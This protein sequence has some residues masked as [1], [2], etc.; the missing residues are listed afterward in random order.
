MMFVLISLI[1]SWSATLT[2]TQATYN[3][4]GGFSMR[5]SG[6]MTD[7]SRY[8]LF[9]M[10]KSIPNGNVFQFDNLKTANPLFITTQL[11]TLSKA[12]VVYKFSSKYIINGKSVNFIPQNP[13][14]PSSTGCGIYTISFDCSSN[15]PPQ[16]CYNFY[17]QV[18]PISNTGSTTTTQFD[19]TNLNNYGSCSAL[20][21]T[22]NNTSYRGNNA[23]YTSE[24]SSC[25]GSSSRATI[26][27]QTQIIIADVSLSP[28]FVVQKSALSFQFLQISPATQN[29]WLIAATKD[30]LWNYPSINPT[31]VF[32]SSFN[33]MPNTRKVYNTIYKTHLVEH[34]YKS[35]IYCRFTLTYTGFVR[36]IY[37]NGYPTGYYAPTGPGLDTVSTMESSTRVPLSSSILN[38]VTIIGLRTNQTQMQFIDCR[39]SWTGT[40][41]LN[42]IQF[43]Y[44]VHNVSFF[45]PQY[46]IS[47]LTTGQCSSNCLKCTAENCIVCQ[48]QYFLYQ[49]KCYG[50]CPNTAPFQNPINICTDTAGNIGALLETPA[51]NKGSVT[52][53]G[54]LDVDD[55]ITYA[56][57]IHASNSMAF[58]NTAFAAMNGTLSLAE[59]YP[60]LLTRSGGYYQVTINLMSIGNTTDLNSRLANVLYHKLDS[61]SL[62]ALPGFSWTTPLSSVS[63]NTL[64]S[65]LTQIPQ[66]SS[67]YSINKK[68]YYI[69][70]TFLA[71][72]SNCTINVTS[73]GEVGLTRNDRTFLFGVNFVTK[74]SYSYSE[75]PAGFYNLQFQ[76]SN[77]SYLDIDII[78]SSLTSYAAT[79]PYFSHEL[80]PLSV[81]TKCSVP[82][83]NNCQGTICLSC[84]TGYY[85]TSDQSN[86]V[87]DCTIY[88]QLN[89]ILERKCVSSCDT[90]YMTQGVASCLPTCKQTGYI[91]SPTQG[92]TP[93]VPDC[94]ICSSANTC[95][96]CQ[97]YSMMVTP[98]F[99][100]NISTIIFPDPTFTKSQTI[101]IKGDANS[102]YVLLVTDES[103]FQGLTFSFLNSSRKTAKIIKAIKF[104]SG[105]VVIP[106][107]Q[108]ADSGRNFIHYIKIQ[109]DSSPPKNASVTGFI[110][111]TLSD[112]STSNNLQGLASDS[113]FLVYKSS[114][115]LPLQKDQY[116]T[117]FVSRLYQHD[118]ASQISCQCYFKFSGNIRKLFV[119]SELIFFDSTIRYNTTQAEVY[120]QSV[121]LNPNQ[122]SLVTIIGDTLEWSDFTFTNCVDTKGKSIT[123]NF[124]TYNFVNQEL[125]PSILNIIN[126]TYC[127]QS[128]DTCINKTQCIQCSDGLYLVDGQCKP[129]CQEPLSRQSLF[130]FCDSVE[131]NQGYFYNYTYNSN[132]EEI[133]LGL[134]LPLNFNTTII[135]GIHP[136]NVSYANYP[137]Y[138]ASSSDNSLTQGSY[139][140]IHFQESTRWNNISIGVQNTID[141]EASQSNQLNFITM[142]V[143]TLKENSLLLATWFIPPSDAS[144]KLKAD[145]SEYIDSSNTTLSLQI[146]YEYLLSFFMNCSSSCHLTINMTGNIE[147]YINDRTFVLQAYI[148]PG[149]GPI[150]LDRTFQG[151]IYFT[152]KVGN[153][154]F[155]Q[156][157]FKEKYSIYAA[158][159]FVLTDIRQ[160]ASSTC[161]VSN[162]LNCYKD[163]CYSCLQGS[164]LDSNGHCISSCSSP[165]IGL[166]FERLCTNKTCESTSMNVN[167]NVCAWNCSIPGI[168]YGQ[169]GC[170]SDNNNKC[171]PMCKECV[172]PAA[173]QC[174]SCYWPRAITA[175]QT[176]IC[177][178]G[179]K[180]NSTGDCIDPLFSVSTIPQ[181]LIDSC[182]NLQLKA[183]VQSVNSTA[184]SVSCSWKQAKLITDVSNQILLS[185]LLM[186]QSTSTL[187]IPSSYLNRNQ[188]YNFT[189]LC[190]NSFG[191]AKSSSTIVQTFGD[192]LINAAILGTD[193]KRFNTFEPNT[194][195]LSVNYSRCLNNSA[196][197]YVI[198]TSTGQN[199][200][201]EDKL[202]NSSNPLQLVI[203]RCYQGDAANF[204]LM[205]IVWV[206]DKIQF[207]KNLTVDMTFSPGIFKATINGVQNGKSLADDDLLLTGEVLPITDCPVTSARTFFYSWSC[208]K[209]KSM[210][211]MNQGRVLPCQDPN[212]IFNTSNLTPQLLVSKSYYSNGDV[213]RFVITIR[214]GNNSATAN[215]TVTILDRYDLPVAI[216]C[217]NCSKYQSTNQYV[218]IGKADNTSTANNNYTYSWTTTPNI[219]FTQIENQITIY[220]QDALPAS[221]NIS[222]K[223]NLKVENMTHRGYAYKIL[224]YDQSLTSG[225]LTANPSSGRSLITRFT[226]T[227]DDWPQNDTNPLKFQFYYSFQDQIIYTPLSSEFGFRQTIKTFLP[228]K[229]PSSLINIQLRARDTIGTES[230]LE[231]NVT[232]VSSVNSL[233]EVVAQAQKLLSKAIGYSLADDLTLLAI[234]SKE[235]SYWEGDTSNK[236]SHIPCPNCSGKGLCPSNI[237]RC[238]C[239]SGWSLS[240]CSLPQTEFDSVAAL[241]NN[242][243]VHLQA[244]SDKLSSENGTEIVY[245]SLQDITKDPEF[246]TNKSLSLVQS[247]L[248]QNLNLTDENTT[249]SMD[250]SESVSHILSN[251]LSFSS[252]YDC[253][254]KTLFTQ[255]LGNVSSVYLSKISQ[256]MLS[257]EVSSVNESVITTHN[258]DVY[259][260]KLSLCELENNKI[261][262]SSNA[263]QI[264]FNISL[265]TSSNCSEQ[266]SIEYYAL[267]NNLLNCA[268]SQ[269]NV[270]KGVIGLTIKNSQTGKELTSGVT[271]NAKM[272]NG[273]SCPTRCSTNPNG[274]CQCRDIS[275]F[276]IKEQMTLIFTQSKL[277][278]LLEYKAVLSFVFWKA[279][280]FWSVLAFTF[281]FF[282]TWCLVTFKYPRTSVIEIY[283]ALS[284]KTFGAQLKAMILV[285]LVFSI[286]NSPLG[287]SPHIEHLFPL[288]RNPLEDFK[289]S[290]ILRTKYPIIG[291]CIDLH[292]Y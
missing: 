52:I 79:Y 66:S 207:A 59:S 83:C 108:F 57:I 216:S 62:E 269:Q 277:E 142:D 37:V 137:N 170:S 264:Y 78:S 181:E 81:Y 73:D 223:I 96:Q 217:Q 34:N 191:Q 131:R 85:L 218:F 145:H 106:P 210:K 50:Q 103:L 274:N 1:L 175:N 263:P 219:S 251:M 187:N 64:V 147:I 141:T 292:R 221:M 91:Y 236:T 30:R 268:V 255:S 183:D 67:G 152:I 185:S 180:S 19:C 237:L 201:G 171:N 173:S 97:P 212:N 112:W 159:Q 119:N 202:Y 27:I 74:W 135:L 69:F 157:S 229:R 115:G 243:L 129:T 259:T 265:N 184:S 160:I 12:T 43:T 146:N 258:F 155:F 41:S 36:N 148:E 13:K 127:D 70:Y 283:K 138:A 94:L 232:V 92:C 228:A 242:M 213:L 95:S 8:A 28:T 275:I 80:G 29:D 151:L 285:C 111:Q 18:P 72:T 273:Q 193:I 42:N 248:E 282:I 45:A 253:D 48:S 225:L 90:S 167:K 260:K 3:P 82:N 196:S 4:Q 2:N 153:S 10:D 179:T 286:N 194:I 20:I 189:V 215:S 257:N 206:G 166:P 116:S 136:F 241:K 270:T 272:P 247:I 190:T 35:T 125:A 55:A 6:N 126:N 164:F 117:I 261:S 289:S 267:S 122:M 161:S 256:S 89:S 65:T 178:T 162:C 86:C 113:G 204:S 60:I 254:D 99:C 24:L 287:H 77:A 290:T 84:N 63:S 143:Y 154:T 168:Y 199:Y 291:L 100:Q 23:K 186:N 120:S 182:S 61:S 130:G 252:I 98:S 249:L 38:V 104:K 21:Q 102:D 51:I 22:F 11:F 230:I 172:G 133:N 33:S 227:T 209:A 177:P 71:C 203:P 245:N 174:L 240:D 149:L 276:N 211:K 39:N 58:T 9:V 266:Y 31:S 235:I 56:M 150:T 118:V 278:A 54:Y 93:C 32:D 238:K 281:W 226:I 109:K 134:F 158:Y 110:N 139:K 208:V 220:P 280:P 197:T 239:E 246:S 68:L 200:F 144:E 14:N 123:P 250:Q 105:N 40:S 165:L 288:L 121:T 224:P 156:Y 5:V 47:T 15:N 49:G 75:I 26:S 244:S 195:S 176:C 284:P 16:Y 114:K 132:T 279:A 192:Y 53:K 17:A 214:N 271:L 101:Q 124:E 46:K 222:L 25:F 88:G 188:T 231:T 76:V 233:A 198:W 262:T 205:A 128:C 163:K 234:I 87:S 140:I 107:L 44:S 7:T 169:N